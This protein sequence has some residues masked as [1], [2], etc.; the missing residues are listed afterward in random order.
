M[1]NY[2]S[3]LVAFNNPS[4]LAAQAG[5]WTMSPSGTKWCCPG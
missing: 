2:G 4:Q 5:K 1:Y 3:L